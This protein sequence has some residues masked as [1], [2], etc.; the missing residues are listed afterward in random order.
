MT[1]FTDGEVLVATDKVG[2]VGMTSGAGR[3]QLRVLGLM[4]KRSGALPVGLPALR[5][6]EDPCCHTSKF[7]TLPGR[8][9]SC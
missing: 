4:L 2:G 1:L 5:G 9:G 6:V 7:I 3:P 8:S